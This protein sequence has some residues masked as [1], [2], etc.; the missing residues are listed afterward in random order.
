MVKDTIY[1]IRNHTCLR[2]VYNH[3][4]YLVEDQ[5]LALRYYRLGLSHVIFLKKVPNLNGMQKKRFD[6]Q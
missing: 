5:S 4:T 1:K 2:I 3:H 6:I